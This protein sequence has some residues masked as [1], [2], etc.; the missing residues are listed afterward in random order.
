[1]PSL[2]RHSFTSEYDPVANVC[3]SGENAALNIVSD[4]GNVAMGNTELL[5]VVAGDS[6]AVIGGG[7]EETRVTVAVEG[8]TVVAAKEGIKR[9]ASAV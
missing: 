3:P 1:M 8:G 6:T 4:P 7:S 9:A 5:L 2:T